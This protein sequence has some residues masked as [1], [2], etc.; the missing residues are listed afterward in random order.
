VK[1]NK[2]INKI[3]S[4]LDEKRDDE[5]AKIYRKAFKCELKA[6]FFIYNKNNNL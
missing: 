6:E 1:I 3:T 5:K 4:D 2:E